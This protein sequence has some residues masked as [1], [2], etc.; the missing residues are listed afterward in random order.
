G[1]A[2]ARESYLDIEKILDACKKTG[3][4]AVHP[5]YGF[6]SENEDFADACD[7]AGITF[8]GPTGD[9]MRMMGDKTSARATVTKA[10]VPV[11]P[12]DN[13]PEG[14]GFPTVEAALAAART[15]GFPVMLKAAAGGGGKDMRLVDSEARFTQA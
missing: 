13:G 7:R 2:P 12:G 5:G 6:L 4:D 14:R 10:G 15:I 8:I 11:V 1:P 3:A 9:S